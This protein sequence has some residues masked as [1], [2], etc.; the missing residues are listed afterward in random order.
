MAHKK[1]KQWKKIKVLVEYESDNPI[2]EKEIV[3]ALWKERP[4][5]SFHDIKV[6]MVK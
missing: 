4:F 1:T 3:R 5:G 6:K 2:T